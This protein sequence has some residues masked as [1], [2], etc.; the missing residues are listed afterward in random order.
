MVLSDVA[1]RLADS[2]A[3]RRECSSPAAV[4]AERASRGPVTSRLHHARCRVVKH[5]KGFG[6]S[7]NRARGERVKVPG[8]DANN[9]GGCATKASVMR[10][11]V[12]RQ[13]VGAALF[14]TGTRVAPL[15]QVAARS[16]RDEHFRPTVTS[17]GD[18][19]DG[20]P[21]KRTK[22]DDPKRWETPGDGADALRRSRSTDQSLAH[23]RSRIRRRRV[24]GLA[25]PSHRSP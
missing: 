15:F 18:H 21:Q 8:V 10:G 24:A 9:S 7:H 17:S 16:G 2:V 3:R 20:V 4:A 23:A 25:W 22:S 11:G 14:T 13:H 19:S 12:P 6:E 5:R 1:T